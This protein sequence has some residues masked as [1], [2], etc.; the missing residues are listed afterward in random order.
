MELEQLTSMVQ[1]EMVINVLM[2][3]GQALLFALLIFVAGRWLALRLTQLAKAA[4]RRSK[5]DDTLVSFLGNILKTILLGLV[6]IAALGQLGVETTSLAAAIAAVGLAIGLALQGSLSNFAAGVMIIA[7]RPFRAGDY[8][9]AG[10]SAGVVKELTIFNTILLTPDNKQVILPNSQITNGA[11][12]NFSAQPT[13]RL[14][15]KIGISYG[16]DIRKAKAVLEDILAQDPRILPEPAPMIIVLALGD[17]SVDIGCRPWV[18]TEDYWPLFW[19]LTE[20][21][22]LRFDEEGITIPFPQRDVHV[23]QVA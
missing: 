21:I 12:T 22:K 19:H 18:K 9:E 20:T 6:I 14:D 15:L 3:Y 16:D 2:E 10:G 11:I 7:F 17:S 13:R 4:L 23:H 1:P 8:I 5:L